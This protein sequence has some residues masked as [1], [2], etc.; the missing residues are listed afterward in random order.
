MSGQTLEEL[1]KLVDKG[2]LLVGFQIN[3]DVDFDGCPTILMVHRD[4]KKFEFKKQFDQ[5]YE[6]LPQ[7]LKNLMPTLE[8]PTKQMFEERWL[9]D[10][11]GFNIVFDGRGK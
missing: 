6:D 10:E 11:H 2:Y 7:F 4:W 5:A 1:M 3:P 9:G 8:I